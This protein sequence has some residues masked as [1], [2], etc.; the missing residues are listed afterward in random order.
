[1]LP[2]LR[3]V[4]LFTALSV[5]TSANANCLAF[6]ENERLANYCLLEAVDGKLVDEETAAIVFRRL[7]LEGYFGGLS[8]P[9]NEFDISPAFYYDDNING[10]NPDKKLRIGNL[11][12][13]GEP[14]LVAKAGIVA[15]LTLSGNSRTTY[16]EGRYLNVTVSA[17]QAY[18]PEH[19]LSY[20]RSDLQICSKNKVRRNAHIDMCG[21]MQRQ[22]KKISSSDGRLL[23]VSYSRM[24]FNE[25][26]ASE[27][28]ISLN[29]FATQEY[30]QSQLMFSSDFI[31]SDNAFYSIGLSLGERI[32]DQLTARYA[33][34][35][36]AAKY[37]E[38]RKY[39][40]RFIRSHSDG[41]KLLGVN[42][43]EIS[44]STIVSTNLTK[45]AVVSLGYSTVKSSIDYFNRSYPTLSLTYSW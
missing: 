12:F 41:G 14:D 43:S 28:K 36:A 38:G 18:S 16:G 23:S 9:L 24:F 17:S 4:A 33:L 32:N 37:Y 40:F 1:M 15:G 7:S 6:T 21:S 2:N 20:T 42:R 34:N 45:S 3:T 25:I 31:H 27:L 30:K 22:N 8:Q 19:S 44:T 29:R 5:A 39:N 10:G 11:E 35:M 13:D 26:G